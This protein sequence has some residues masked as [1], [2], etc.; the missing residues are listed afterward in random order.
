MHVIAA[1][2]DLGIQQIQSQRLVIVQA[3]TLDRLDGPGRRFQIAVL[4]QRFS[5]PQ[6]EIGRLVAVAAANC[7]FQKRVGRLC[8]LAFAQQLVGLCCIGAVARW[9]GR[10]ADATAAGEYAHQQQQA[11]GM[12]DGKETAQGCRHDRTTTATLSG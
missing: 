10:H 6:A 8:E 7:K 4:A 3:A 5:C 12:T 9:R 2:R 11:N 1:Q